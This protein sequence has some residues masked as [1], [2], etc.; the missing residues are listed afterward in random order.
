MKERIARRLEYAYPEG[1]KVLGEYWTFGAD[2]AVVLVT[3]AED[4]GAIMAATAAWD[5]AFEFTILPAVTAEEG[6]R[7]AKAA[8][9][10]E[11][12]ARR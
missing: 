5:D 7:V 9:A 10:Q 8:L 2:P 3:E 11:A 4:P 12:L 1:V 6:I